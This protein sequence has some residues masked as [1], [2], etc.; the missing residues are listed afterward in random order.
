MNKFHHLPVMLDIVHSALSLFPSFYLP[1][2]LCDPTDLIWRKGAPFEAMTLHSLFTRQSPS[3]SFLGFS[4]AVRQMPGDMC[5]APGI[6]SLSPLSLATYVTDATLVASGL[7][8]GTRTGAG[9]TDT[10]TKFFWPQPM[11]PWTTDPW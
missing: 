3:W 11:A 7:W 5:T 4:S 10:L 8:L 9:G 1:D 6:I 2:V